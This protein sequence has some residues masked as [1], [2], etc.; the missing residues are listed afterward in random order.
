LR[1]IADLRLEGLVETC[2]ERWF[3]HFI[4]MAIETIDEF[5]RLHARSIA[6]VAERGGAARLGIGAETVCAALHESVRTWASSLAAEPDARA[7]ASYLDGL[8]AEGL[9]L[10]CACRAGDARAWEEFIARYRGGMIAAARALAHDEVRAQEMADSLYAELYGLEERAGERRSLLSY[11]HG[12]GSLAAWIRAVIAQR[13]ADAHRTMARAQMLGDALAR[14]A[15][16]GL[17]LTIDPPDPNRMRYIESI[18]AAMAAA[19]RELAARDRLRLNLYYAEELTLKQVGRAMKEHESGVSR[20]LARTR[21]HLRRR[22]ERILKREHRLTEEQ[23]R[24]CYVYAI[25]EWPAHFSLL[26]P[27]IER[28]GAK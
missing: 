2:G 16:S 28:E 27:G 17:A 4:P 24:L 7:T 20:H 19:V 9:V 12:R 6:A 15:P 22:V 18:A 13:H 8:N 26:R 14:D 21:E 25:E 10:A 23:I 11:Y 1:A 5:R 3:D